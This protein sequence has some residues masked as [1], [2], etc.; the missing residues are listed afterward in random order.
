MI[1]QK[2]FLSK[3]R[4]FGL[5]TYESKLWTA[6]LSRGSSTAGELSDIANVPRSRTYD[7]LESLER[8][9]FIIR[10][11]GKPIKYIAVPPEEVVD[12]VKDKV[13][14]ESEQH[15]K[16]IDSLKDSEALNELNLLHLQGVELV[17]PTDLT[18]AITGRD[19]L[20]NHIESRIAKAENSVSI[21]TTSDGFLRKA[22]F[23]LPVLKKLKSKGVQVRIATQIKKDMK[24][25]VA[26]ISK[27]ADVR[28]T[29]IKGRF[30]IINKEEVILM[31]LDDKVVH[32]SYDTA[33]WINTKFFSTTLEKI[34]DAKWQDMKPALS[35]LK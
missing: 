30:C 32:P 33:V 19:N 25:I 6:L 15:L 34:F 16:M 35:M 20:N 7:V 2:N 31:L 5:N 10:K 4:D 18:G 9:G 23:L 14:K 29:D 3:L 28:H 26:E 11:L 17:E 27:Y 1:V 22:N 13:K 12:R 8:K 21:L 24:D